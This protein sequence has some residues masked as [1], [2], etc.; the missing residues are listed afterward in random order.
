MVKSEAIQKAIMKAT[1]QTAT[2]AAKAL[3]E[4]DTRPNSGTST[5]K[6]G[7][8]H[9]PRHS[10]SALRQVSFNWKTLDRYVELLNFEMEVT[11]ILQTRTYELNDEQSINAVYNKHS[12]ILKKRHAKQ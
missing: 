9:R 11:D 1:I 2:A 6:I 7:E 10:R 5:A 3:E 12:Q 4:A 8:A